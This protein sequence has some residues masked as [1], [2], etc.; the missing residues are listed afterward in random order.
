MECVADIWNG[1]VP[2]PVDFS[3]L[4]TFTGSTE[5]NFY[6]YRVPSLRIAFWE[7]KLWHMGVARGVLGVPGPSVWK[8]KTFKQAWNTK[9]EYNAQNKAAL[10]LAIE[11]PA[12]PVMN[13]GYA[14]E[15]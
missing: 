15:L 9:Y 4:T 1:L 3:S 10:A 13:P 6:E 8:L 14:N 5:I 2:N 7:G 12:H 11:T